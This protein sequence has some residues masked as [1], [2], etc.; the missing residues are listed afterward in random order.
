METENGRGILEPLPTIVG[1][2][3]AQAVQ[4]VS[5]PGHFL[6]E[7]VMEFLLRRALHDLA[8]LPLMLQFSISTVGDEYQKEIG[9]ILNVLAVGLRTEQVCFPLY[10]PAA[11]SYAA[12]QVPRHICRIWI[13]TVDEISSVAASVYTYPPIRPIR[14]RRRLWISFGMPRPSKVAAPH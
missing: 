13:S 5:N 8:D 11:D 4:I 10:L 7:K 3:F 6:Y 9:W 2:F 12:N 1:V 14:S